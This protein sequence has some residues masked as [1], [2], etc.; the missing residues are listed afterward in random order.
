MLKKRERKGGRG[1]N[2]R[3]T[4]WRDRGDER[5][6]FDRRDDEMKEKKRRNQ[7]KRN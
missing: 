2:E 3:T 7:N 4:I 5:F 1:K 6:A